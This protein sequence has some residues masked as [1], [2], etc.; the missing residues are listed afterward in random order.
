MGACGLVFLLLRYPMIR[1]F[2]NTPPNLPLEQAARTMAEVIRLGGWVMICAAV[3]QLGDAIGIVYMSALRG[4]GD[5]LRPM[6]MTISLSWGV[7]VGG[8]WL[9][10]EALPQLASVG[11]WIAGALYVILLGLVM[12][13]RFEGGAWRKIDLLHLRGIPAAP[14]PAAPLAPPGA[15][16]LPES[17]ESDSSH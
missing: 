8:G 17:R 5:T 6:L 12:A 7:M 11:P 4:A 1:M 10:T 3:F 16:A 14:V 2:V 15:I 13:R 9:L